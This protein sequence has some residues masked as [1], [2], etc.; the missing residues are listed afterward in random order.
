VLTLPSPVSRSILQW[1]HAQRRVFGFVVWVPSIDFGIALFLV[2]SLLFGHHTTQL[3]PA[4]VVILVAIL[5]FGLLAMGCY[6]MSVVVV[7]RDIAQN[8]QIAARNQTSELLILYLSGPFGPPLYWKQFMSDASFEP[9]EDN[10][11]GR[12]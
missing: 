2:G 9:R 11:P 6:A 8:T 12:V 4:V 7:G 1:T 10:V 5:L 3:T